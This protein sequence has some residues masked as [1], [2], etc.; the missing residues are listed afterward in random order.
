MCWI[1]KSIYWILGIVV[2]LVVLLAGVAYA[3]TT[4]RVQLWLFQKSLTMLSERLD[5][6][7]E[8]DSLKVNPWT[9]DISLY[10]FG[11]DDLSKVEMLR[12]DTL[13][14]SLSVKHLLMRQVVV[15]ELKLRNAS[16]V[17]YKE[18]KDSAANFQFVVEAFKKK[19]SANDKK[20]KKAKK[21]PFSFDLDK[22]LISNLHFKWDVRDQKRKNEGKPH[23]GAFDANHVDAQLDLS[24]SLNTIKKDSIHA[25]I[26]HLCL[27][28]K[29]SG[30]YV[31]E[32]TTEAAFGKQGVTLHDLNLALN[33]TKIQMGTIKA[34]YHTTPA[35]TIK[36]TKK[37]IDLSI[38][39]FPLHADV[40]LQDIAAPF[41]P[42]LNHFTTP[43]VLDV[44]VGGT[45]DRFTFSNIRVTSADKRL[46]LT[47]QGDLCNVTK[48]KEALCLHFTGIKMS[49]RRGIKEQIINHFAKKVNLKMI[50]QL[51]AVGDI[52]YN[53]SLGIF[54]KYERFRGMLFTKFGNVNFNFGLDGI[55]KYMNGTLYTDSLEVGK[56][57]NVP[58]MGAVGFH[59]DY[60]FNLSSKRFKGQKGIKQGRLPQG[61][62]KASVQN[63]KYKFIHFKEIDVDVQSNGSVASGMVFVPQKPLDLLV[64]FEYTQTVDK[65]GIKLHP[66]LKV[67]HKKKDP[68]ATDDAKPKKSFAEKL[69][70]LFKK[71]KK[72]EEDSTNE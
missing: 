39:P 38:E 9:G 36:G 28:D 6:R 72:A 51:K 59:A 24:A 21:E 61:W 56:L 23:H 58:E 65:Q 62:L 12:V 30:L 43:L 18:R 11:M 63:A 32:L 20:D 71:K 19:P 66:T 54:Y 2:V 50:R 13:Q 48:G 40:Y 7:V 33:K 34:A 17:I 68:A 42:V 14:V 64:R 26:K 8:A 37:K 10:G 31:K 52:R 55:T 3:L 49:A 67:H 4:D 29:A 15:D 60:K 44:N 35:D 25:N 45:L 1:R 22:I 16:A 5:T 53:G 47:A 46:Q 27:D 57:M 70:G 41:A 69:K